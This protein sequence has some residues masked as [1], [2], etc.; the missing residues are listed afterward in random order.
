MA[1]LVAFTGPGTPRPEGE[2]VHLDEHHEATRQVL[3][4]SWHKLCSLLP[5]IPA[6]YHWY[7]TAHTS[8]LLPDHQTTTDTDPTNQCSVT[9]PSHFWYGGFHIDATVL[10]HL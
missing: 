8:A 9:R 3:L 1:Q 6:N 2:A 5:D 4:V 7:Q 10:T